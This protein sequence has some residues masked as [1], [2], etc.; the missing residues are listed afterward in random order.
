MQTQAWKDA[1]KL[2]RIPFSIYLMPVYCFALSNTPH[3]PFNHALLIFVILHL[4]V[5]PASN[6]YN[7]FFDRDEG[8]IGG[9]KH[10]P[11]PNRQ[12]FYLVVLF[13]LLAVGLSLLISPLFALGVGVYLLVSKAYSYDRIRLK[14]YPYLSTLVVCS[15]QGAYTY[16]LVLYGLGVEAQALFHGANMRFALVSTLFLCGSYPLTQIYQHEEDRRRGDI[17]LSLKLG[18]AGTFLFSGISMLL[19]T[20]LLCDTYWQLGQVY[21]IGIFLLAGAPVMGVFGHWVWQVLSQ[22]QPPGFGQSMRMNQVASLALSTAFVLMLLL[23]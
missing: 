11:P 17:T 4:L 22:G 16:W 1:L 18:V 3:I 10:P 14:K 12:L 23:S 7:S 20:G 9:L 6:G 15:F 5:Y 19:A 21:R 2:M 8:S 13:D